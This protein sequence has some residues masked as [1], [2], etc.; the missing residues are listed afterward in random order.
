MAWTAPAVSAWMASTR[1]AMS[2]VAVAVS[3]ARFCSYGPRLSRV[4]AVRSGGE[5]VISRAIDA[6][7]AYAVHGGL[8]NGLFSERGPG[9]PR[10]TAGS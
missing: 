2:S 6:D 1:W 7:Q 5:E 8:L 4:A 9:T 3:R 10:R